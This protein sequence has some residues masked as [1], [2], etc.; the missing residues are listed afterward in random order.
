MGVLLASDKEKDFESAFNDAY[1]FWF[2]WIEE[3]HTDIK[4]AIDN[5]WT[6]AD[7]Q[8]MRDEKREIL[9]FPVIRRV[10]K[11]ITGYERRNRLT[12]KISPAEGSDKQIASQLSGLIMPMMENRMGHQ[13]VSDCFEFGALMA[14]AGLIEPYLDRKGD[15]QFNRE[16]YNQFLLDPNFRRRD[17]K[18]CRHIII[19]KPDM[20][21]DEIKSLVPGKG[22]RIKEI[23]KSPESGLGLPYGASY[24]RGD[25]DKGTLSYFWERTTKEIQFLGNRELGQQFEWTGTKKALKEVVQRYQGNIQTWTDFKDTVKLTVLVNGQEV[26]KGPDPNGIDDYNYVLCAGYYVPEYD[27]AAAKLQGIVRPLRDC[28]KELDKRL[29]KILDMIDSQIQTGMIAEEGALVDNDQIHGSGQGQGVWVKQG[30]M[31]MVE[32]IEPSDIPAGLFQLNN[33]LQ[34][35]VNQ[36]AGINESMFGTEELKA[37]V[38]GY[39]LKLRQ[40]AGLVSLQ[41]LFDNLRFTK[42]QLGFTIAKLL[43]ANYSKAKIER[44]L[45]KPLAPGFF[46][47]DLTRYDI[48]PEEGILTSTQQQAHYVELR[49]LKESGAPIPWKYILEQYQSSMPDELMQAIQQ[50]EQQQ[51]QASKQAQQE[52]Q[53]L[54]RMRSAKIEADLG[55]AGERRT[56]EEENRTNATLNRAKTMAEIQDMDHQK[57][58]DLLDR[59]IAIENLNRQPTTT[60]R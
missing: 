24:N 30:K 45:N 31:G 32:K 54:D 17:L 50:A 3:A 60:K 18:D 39:L 12:L 37:Q 29:S 38:S 8:K 48:V 25:E 5:P 10:V 7:R 44:I 53:L 34:G 40:G 6:A 33:D 9:H 49:Q 11:L 41:D 56:Q 23:I 59:V 19:H 46:K 57:Q 27:D 2:P 51:A 26:W 1:D 35:M 58:M 22:T 55:R 43:Q 42:K 4:H 13:V 52:K 14:G 15:I 36:I 47:E 21:I 28:G 16:F 20:H